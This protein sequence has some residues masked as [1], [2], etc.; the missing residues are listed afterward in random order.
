MAKEIELPDGS[1]A[2]FPD[3]MDDAAIKGVLQKKFGAPQQPAAPEQPKQQ[4]ASV[5]KRA[6]AGIADPGI[7]IAQIA[8]KVLVNP[9]R[10]LVSPG[11]SSMDDYIREREAGLTAPE[12]IDVARMAGNVA[13]PVN[14]MGGGTSLPAS[15]AARP[16]AKAALAGAAG[17]AMN[18]VSPDD[19]FIEQ[20]AIQA[21][22]GGA[23][24]A[25]VSK[26]ARGFTPTSE[27][28]ELINRGVQPSFGQSMGGFANRTEQNLT[29]VPIVGD[30]IGYARNR[31]S[32][33]FEK[34]ALL[35]ATGGPVTGFKGSTL[36]DANEFASGLY[37]SVVPNLRPTR[38]AVVNVQQA[39]RNAL[40]P[41]VTPELTDQNRQIFSGLV[42]KYFGNFGNLDGAAIKRLDSELGHIA[43]SYAAG[44]PQSKVLAREIWNLQNEF[45]TGLEA[46]LTGAQQAELRTANTVWRNLIPLNKA[47]SAR[48]DERIMPRALQKAMARQQRKDP[49]MADIGPLV[50]AGV[51]VLPST[52]PDSGTAGRMM[53]GGG[54]LVG[55]GSLGVLPQ[56]LAVGIPAAVGAT[57]P[58]QRALVGNTAWQKALQPY[59]PEVA[60]AL[61]AALRQRD[62]Q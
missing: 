59:D 52:V 58:V 32:K 36:D 54:A 33:E 45:R 10:Q 27:A 48:A 4:P 15:L 24:G 43:R 50:D 22:L 29:S 56:M 3:N 47:A 44:D 5:L 12:G 60:A 18:P 23:L 26:V 8:D 21:G 62:V 14:Y 35:E 40:D 51:K 61:A 34:T 17:S 11:A 57:R 9:I 41:Q 1:I 39:V 13:S 49:T 16:V 46:G 20:K 38:E 28:Q 53:L 6:L 7:G 55:G 2:E 42:N 30:A 37:N 31:A 25:G 19:N